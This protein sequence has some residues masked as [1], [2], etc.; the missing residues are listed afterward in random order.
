MPDAPACRAHA[1][2]ILAHLQ[3]QYDRLGMTLDDHA[4]HQTASHLLDAIHAALCA[5]DLPPDVS[6]VYQQLERSIRTQMMQR[7]L[8]P[9]RPLF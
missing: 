6:A 8:L 1:A 4:F 7:Q 2:A 9:S 5:D 3:C